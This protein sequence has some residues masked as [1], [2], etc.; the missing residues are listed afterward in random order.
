MIS[1]NWSFKLTTNTYRCSRKNDYKWKLKADQSGWIVPGFFF[2]IF[3]S[4]SQ[5]FGKIIDSFVKSAS[6]MY[7]L[8]IIE[9]FQ[10]L[11]MTV[12]T[13]DTKKNNRAWKNT[14]WCR[15]RISISTEV[16]C[17]FY[18]VFLYH[19]ENCLYIQK[20]FPYKYKPQ[21]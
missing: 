7:Q 11:P 14:R 4:F 2:S 19:S 15:F 20:I 13:A 9:I 3:V 6:L 1:L 5:L 21:I 18:S 10:K 12:I 17:N 16:F 8:D